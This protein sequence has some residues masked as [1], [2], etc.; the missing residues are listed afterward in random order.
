MHGDINAL[1][2]TFARGGLKITTAMKRKD[3]LSAYLNGARSRAPKKLLVPRTGWHEVG[4][5][6]TFV[7]PGIDDVIVE[8]ALNSPY[9]SAGTLDDWK[10]CRRPLE[11]HH[12]AVLAISMA[13]AAPL[14][15]LTGE[16]GGG[17]NIKGLSSIGK[18]A[19]VTAAASAGG[20][21]VERGGFLR[22]WRSTANG[23]EGVAALFNDA[24]RRF[25]VIGARSPYRGWQYCLQPRRRCREAAGEAGRQC[26]GGGDVERDDFVVR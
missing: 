4:G 15:D 17:A 20:C 2:A 24:L 9:S 26:Q 22:T 8:N 5:R 3:H 19:L 12:L 6:K 25:D 14:L 21:C 18:T 11:G 23:I 10:R 1:C 13:F 16:G 7:L